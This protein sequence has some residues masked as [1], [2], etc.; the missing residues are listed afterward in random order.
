M[1]KTVIR[2]CYII[3]FIVGITAISVSSVATHAASAELSHKIVSYEAASLYGNA[4]T[5]I[6]IKGYF[7][8][9]ATSLIEV[10]Y[11][12]VK[13]FMKDDLV[14]VDSDTGVI[15][16]NGKVITNDEIVVKNSIKEENKVVQVK[17]VGNPTAQR[18]KYVEVVAYEWCAFVFGVR[19]MNDDNQEAVT[20]ASS[21]YT[22]TSIDS[23]TPE[24][25]NNRPWIKFA[26]YIEYEFLIK[27][28]KQNLLRSEES[29]LSRVVIYK[30]TSKTDTDKVEIF[31]ETDIGN[32]TY[33]Y[34]LK[35]YLN[36]KAYYEINVVDEAGNNLVKSLAEN[37]N[38]KFDEGFESAFKNALNYLDDNAVLYSPSVKAN[39]ENA[40]YD[41][42]MQVQKSDQTS[43]D[44][45]IVEMNKT[46]PYLTEFARLKTLQQSGKRE[47]LIKVTNKEYVNG[48]ITLANADT[49]LSTLLYG[50]KATV[51]VTLA[52]FN[53]SRVNKRVEMQAA[54]V[55]NCKEILSFT[56]NY[57][58]NSIEFNEQ[59]NVPLQISV[60]LTGY[61]NIKAVINIPSEDGSYAIKTIDINEYNDYI[62]LNTTYSYGTISLFIDEKTNSPLLWLLTLLIIPVGLFIFAMIK[63]I[64][65]NKNKKVEKN[66]KLSK[67]ARSNKRKTLN[68]KS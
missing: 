29:N 49:A 41:Y 39:L 10:T 11:T 17:D 65:K 46:L 55:K 58:K 12:A 32:R 38:R 14:S 63:I 61:K 6:Q 50:E 34:K 28:N 40:Y 66:D 48:E 51:N 62:V 20:Y 43:D 64:S 25:Y 21:I 44:A 2:L 37:N 60:P 5:G 18:S 35:V 4:N 52:L 67:Q 22:C 23:G 3:M 26:E 54:G 13:I 57:T 56:I 1:K 16:L 30:G 7:S 68:N 53:P 24:V 36:E 47:W 8:N 27:S 59:F 31:R 45:I 9:E 15:S 42:Y 33:I 19:F